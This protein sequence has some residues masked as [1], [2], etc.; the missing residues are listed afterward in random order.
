V[1]ACIGEAFFGKF[2]TLDLTYEEIGLNVY[3]GENNLSDFVAYRGVL[4][5]AFL[6]HL[7]K[8]NVATRLGERIF[9]LKTD[10]TLTDIGKE[11]HSKSKQL[12]VS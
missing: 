7:R 5:G 8:N 11:A 4:K 6:P 10:I 3:L 2:L 12:V 1:N 9:I